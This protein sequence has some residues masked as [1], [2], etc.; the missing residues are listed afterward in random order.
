MT[1]PLTISSA[2]ARRSWP[3]PPTSAFRGGARQRPGDADSI[4][5]L[6][7]YAQGLSEQGTHVQIPLPAGPD[8]SASSWSLTSAWMRRPATRTLA[9]VAA[10]A[11]AVGPGIARADSGSQAS[12]SSELIPGSAKHVDLRWH[13]GPSQVPARTPDRQTEDNPGDYPPPSGASLGVP[14][15]ILTA[16]GAAFLA[17]FGISAAINPYAV[18]YRSL[19]YTT[20]GYD[21]PT[22]PFAIIGGA[23]LGPGI[24]LLAAG[25]ARQEKRA[26]WFEK[27][28]FDGRVSVSAGP[29]RKGWQGR[30]SVRF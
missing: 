27:A 6:E 8:E 7:A 1:P 23:L 16:A 12:A 10:G 5:L 29:T 14:G 13:G 9:A 20:Y 17:G 28:K 25:A 19:N 2:A 4:A 22:F 24:P 26:R 11:I 15:A 3:A 18:I 30:L 21:G